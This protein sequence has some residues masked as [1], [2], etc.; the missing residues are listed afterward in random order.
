[1]NGIEIEVCSVCE[2]SIY[3]I[4]NPTIRHCAIQRR[5]NVAKENDTRGVQ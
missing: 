4:I 1:V 2:E 5:V 3:Y